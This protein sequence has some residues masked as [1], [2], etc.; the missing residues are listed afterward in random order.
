M[1][2]QRIVA[3]YWRRSETAIT[4]T[5]SKYGNYFNNVSYNNPIFRCSLL[6][7]KFVI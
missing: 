4:E 5:A 2:V 3:L 1:D 7:I 6:F